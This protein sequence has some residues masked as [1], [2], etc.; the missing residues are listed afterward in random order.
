MGPGEL[1]FQLRQQTVNLLFIEMLQRFHSGEGDL[2]VGKFPVG[3][4]VLDQ[5]TV[6]HKW[7]SL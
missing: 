6:I 7:A 5:C 2:L 3:L 4:S 1:S